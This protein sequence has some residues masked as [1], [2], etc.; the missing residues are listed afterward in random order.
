MSTYANRYENSL[1][2]D[3]RTPWDEPEPDEDD[4]YDYEEEHRDYL[5]DLRALDNHYD[6][7]DG[8]ADGD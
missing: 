3:G 5:D 2:G 7:M 8:A 6:E 4:D 1:V